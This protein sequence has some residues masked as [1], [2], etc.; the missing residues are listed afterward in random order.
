MFFDAPNIEDA[1]S[2]A[3]TKII[4]TAT[5]IYTVSKSISFP[6][7]GGGGSDAG[8]TSAKLGV[9]ILGSMKLGT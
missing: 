3:H 2:G 7:S 8:P 5:L 6:S 1:E 4:D 9:A